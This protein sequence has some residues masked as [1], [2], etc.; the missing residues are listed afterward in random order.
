MACLIVNT[1]SLPISILPLSVIPWEESIKYL[2][3]DKATVLEWYDN[4]IVNSVR[5]ST[6]VPAVM[7]LKHY[8]KKKNSVRFS[9]QNVFLRDRYICQYCQIPVNKKTAT[10]DHILPISHG[11]KTQ[12]ENT[13]CSC[14]KCNS[15]KGNNTKIKPLIKLYKPNYFELAENRKNLKW[16]FLHRSWANY[17][18]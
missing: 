12:W 16:D 6:K 14:I 4:W 9:K 10:L 13:C 3:T 8:Q 1:D 2:V 17:I 5:W 7:M 15:K 18:C 11:G